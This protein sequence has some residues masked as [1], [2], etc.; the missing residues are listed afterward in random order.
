MSRHWG[1]L[2]EALS[3]ICGSG[4]AAYATR[5]YPEHSPAAVGALIT[6]FGAFFFSL[7]TR[8]MPGREKRQPAKARWNR[9][10]WKWVLVLLV[11][12][13]FQ[14]QVQ[15]AAL[16]RVD[17]GTLMT[18]MTLGALGLATWRLVS[19]PQ[20]SGRG[21]H[22]L[23]FLIGLVGVAMLARPFTGGT[24]TWGLLL[25]GLAAVIGVNGTIASGKL[26]ELGLLSRV[27]ELNCWAGACLVGVPI[28]I[29][30]DDR[31]LTVSVLSTVAVTSLL[32]MI[33]NQLHIRAFDLVQSDDGVISTV[34]CVNPVLACLVGVVIGTG[35]SPGLYGWIGAGLVVGASLAALRAFHRHGLHIVPQTVKGAPWKDLLPGTAPNGGAWGGIPPTDVWLRSV[36][37]P[38]DQGPWKYEFA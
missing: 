25:V 22:V 38:D 7:A 16:K 4:G 6:I 23:W 17:V 14:G 10:K 8:L 11:P 15:Q 30:T 31:W 18:V 19:A 34:K 21:L 12:S 5:L 29:W 9:R 2:A 28:L 24:G 37:K 3:L 32:N 20:R 36:W 27:V 26:T 1:A 33:G 35:G 13:I